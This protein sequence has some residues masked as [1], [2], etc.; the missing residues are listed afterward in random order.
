MKV[1]RPQSPWF[2]LRPQSQVKEAPQCPQFALPAS[3]GHAQSQALY[4]SRDVE[5]V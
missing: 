3:G 4:W 5:R 1:R 2:A